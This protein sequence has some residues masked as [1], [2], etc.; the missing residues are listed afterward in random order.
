MSNEVNIVEKDIEFLQKLLPGDVLVMYS[1]SDLTS[2]FIRWC[3]GNQYTHVA[4][5]IESG[6]LIEAAFNGVREIHWAK[7]GYKDN[8]SVVALRKTGITSEQVQ[9]VIDFQKSKVGMFYDYIMLFSIAIIWSFKK[10]GIDLR[11]Y[12]NRIEVNHMYT[13]IELLLDSFNSAGIKLISDNISRSQGVP[14]D[15]AFRGIG[16]EKVAEYNI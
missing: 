12:R 10:I 16:L 4:T 8:Y 14:D 9:K 11:R 2:R 15:L 13:C 7:T 6:N 1:K 5:H 3:S